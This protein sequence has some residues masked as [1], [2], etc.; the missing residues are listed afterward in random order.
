MR[1]KKMLRNMIMSL[2]L[3]VVT[4]ACGLILPRFII[5][6]YGSSTNGLIASITQFLAYISLIAAGIGQV[7][8]AVLYKP[9]ANKDKDKIER[10]LKSSQKFL[11]KIVIVFVIYLVALCIFYPMLVNGE[12]SVPFTVSLIIII[13]LSTSAE[14]LFGMT[15]RLYLQAKQRAYVVSIIQIATLILNT[16][17]SVIMI[18]MGASIQAVKLFSAAVFILRPIIQSAYVKKKYK[19]DFRKNNGEYTLK[20]RWDGLVQHIAYVIHENTDVVVLTVFSTTAEISVYTVYYFVIKG[21]KGFIQALQTGIEAVF[22]DMYARNEKENLNKKVGLYEFVYFTMMAVIFSCTMALITPFVQVYTK[23][24]TDVSYFRPIFGYIMVAAELMWAIRQPYNI[25]VLSAGHFKQT[26]RGAIIEAVTNVVVSLA[27]VWKLGIIGV[28]I[29]TLVAM[30]V[31]TIDF[32]IYAS[33]NIIFRDKIVAFERLIVTCAE[34]ALCSCVL[35]I[36]VSNTSFSSYLAWGLWAIIS[37]GVTLAVIVPVNC[38][39]YKD[40]LK[41]IIQFLKRGRSKE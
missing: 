41:Q 21:I 4:I 23:G 3:Q 32:M 8:K 10:I 26:R 24:I 36:F 30:F 13:S 31:R 25:L 40:D 35:C 15:Y 34:V 29:G 12:F 18:N 6:H 1:A 39:L 11:N 16:I 14:Y 2:F 28:A 9:I 38:L 5:S 33:K 20:Q 22:G 37:I 17:V 27:L 7:V 19:I